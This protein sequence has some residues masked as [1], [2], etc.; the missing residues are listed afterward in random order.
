MDELLR[1]LA[2]AQRMTTA[3]DEAMNKY[4]GYSWGYYGQSEITAMHKAEQEVKDALDKV[5][6]EKIYEVLKRRGIA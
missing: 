5:I 2:Y 4:Q 3:H 1:A 6:E